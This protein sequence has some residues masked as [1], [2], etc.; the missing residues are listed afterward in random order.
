MVEKVSTQSLSEPDEETS[1]RTQNLRNVRILLKKGGIRKEYAELINPLKV[2]SRITVH[3]YLD[4]RLSLG[5]VEYIDGVLH[6][7]T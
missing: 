7:A 4:M 2:G 5:D 3:D 1:Q 6:D